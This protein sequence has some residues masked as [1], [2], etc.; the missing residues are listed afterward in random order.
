MN[1]TKEIPHEVHDGKPA[2]DL[3]AQTAAENGNKTGESTGR[4][5]HGPNPVLFRL[6]YEKQSARDLAAVLP[7]LLSIDAAHVVMLAHTGLLPRKVAAELLGVNRELTR[8]MDAGR[9]VLPTRPQHRGF[10]FMYEQEYIDRLGKQVGGAAHLARSRNDINATVTRSR[11]REEL[12][13]LLEEFCSLSHIMSAAAQKHSELVIC[14][15][16][17]M[18]PAQPSTLGHYL[19]A[20]LSELLRSAELL[21]GVY[22]VVNCCPM[23]AAAGLGTSFPIDRG[24]VAQL[25]GFSSIVQNSADAVAS[26]DYLVYSLSGMAMM[27]VSLTRLATDFQIW[28]SA[29]YGF[30]G[31]ADDLVS[32]SS[33]MPQKRNAFVWENIRGK[34]ITP[35]G[36]LVNTLTGM[37]NVSFNNTVEVSAEASE[38]IW[39]ALKGMVQALQLV[40]LLIKHLQVHPGRMR[41]FLEDKQTTMTALAD[42]L[43]ARYGL[44]FRLAHD[45]VSRFVN[46]CPGTIPAAEA[47]P[48]LEEII[49][50]AANLRLRLDPD[51]LSL[52]LD[53]T[54]TAIAATYGGGP[55]PVAVRSQLRSL[56]R[57]V[58]AIERELHRRRR[59]LSDANQNLA[60][61]ADEVMALQDRRGQA[62]LQEQSVTV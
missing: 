61:M 44:A 7:H 19:A 13:R 22:E 40:R 14:G 28:S 34:A 47:T 46:Q 60:A 36:E 56:V 15:F 31:W 5:S 23:G 16:T 35:I 39:P 37:K 2:T 12:L 32:T 43:V 62:G 38:H 3:Y 8:L 51:E 18:Q 53:L 54:G 58:A 25:L 4:L 10:Y 20:L 49:S 30:L 45:C 26:R 59:R 24:E 50:Q 57:R 29:A 21:D 9:E 55:G 41:Q 52:A 42:L 1:S 11:L 17:H 6:L 48:I 27:G 33:I